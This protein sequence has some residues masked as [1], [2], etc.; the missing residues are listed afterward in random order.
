MHPTL[1]HIGPLPLHSYGL[2]LA[3]SFFFGILLASRRAPARGLHPDLIF[4]ASLVIVFASI[5][6]ARLMY[7]LFHRN[8]MHGLLDV[9]ALWSGGLTMYGGVLA[10]MG[11]SWWFLRR[12]RVAFLT[13]ADVVAPS[14]ALG[15][16]LTRIGCF[17][18]G[19]CYGKPTHS[20]LGVV[21]PPDSFVGRFFEGQALHPTQ[22]YSSFTGLLI[23]GVLLLFDRRPRRTGQVFALYLMLD[24]VGRFILDFFRYYEAN[25]Y[26]L[27]GLTVNQ[28]I[29]VGLFGL[30]VLLFIR[31]NRQPAAVEKV[32]AA[33]IGP[34][35][36]SA[37]SETR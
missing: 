37:V 19:C 18:N 24:A 2:M 6:G 10:A 26:V 20:P 32:E 7:V 1:I 5:L 8:E 9:V 3:L 16:G 15:L 23:L 28:L 33:A 30:G 29:C 31:S 21:F 11:A 27:R 17:L 25:V 12:R 13:M 35:V 34:I 36:P 4:D 14:L 22:L